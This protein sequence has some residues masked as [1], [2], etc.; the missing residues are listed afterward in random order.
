MA[1]RQTPPRRMGRRM[2]RSDNGNW[3]A[4]IP[5]VDAFVVVESA[6]PSCW[7][8]QT[9]DRQRELTFARASGEQA[10]ANAAQDWLVSR[11]ELTLKLAGR[12]P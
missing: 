12:K 8:I 1:L 7:R 2:S 11:A 10:A 5:E 4:S 9:S 3:F 6:S